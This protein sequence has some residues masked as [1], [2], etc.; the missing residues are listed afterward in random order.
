MKVS[1]KSQNGESIGVLYVLYLQTPAGVGFSYRENSQ[2]YATDDDQVARDNHEAMKHFFIKFPQFKSNPFFVTGESYGG[3]Y[4][5]TLAVE[6][7]RNSPDINL[8]GYSIGNGLLETEKLENSHLLFGHLHGLFNQTSWNQLSETCCGIKSDPPADVQGTC[9]FQS[10]AI[11]SLECWLAIEIAI[12][13]TILSVTRSGLNPYNIDHDCKHPKDASNGNA[14]GNILRPQVNDPP[15]TDNSHLRE[16]LNRNSVRSALHI[17]PNVAMWDTCSQKVSS[18]YI[19]RYATVK[20]LILELARA[21]KKGLIYYGDVDLVCPFL[22]GKWFV[23]DLGLKVISD[24]KGW[25]LNGQNA[26][27]IKHFENLVFATVRGAGHEV[28]ADKP[29]AALTLIN[30]FLNQAINEYRKKNLLL[31]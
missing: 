30:D 8:Q 1:C 19:N 4:V 13:E 11:E 25:K 22:S 23:H 2:K 29:E 27:S 17:P 24:Y 20:P 28:P 14:E 18:S 9:D 31:E 12:E 5:P 26:G 10:S 16:Y 15:C 21:G 6:I 7:L 3:I